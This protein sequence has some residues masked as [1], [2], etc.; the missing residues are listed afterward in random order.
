MHGALDD[1]I[2]AI[3]T[4]PGEGGI[5]VV[6]VSGLHAL[7]V[8][9]QVVFP[10]SGKLLS[11]LLSHKMTV[12]D[13]CPPARTSGGAHGGATVARTALDE[14]LVVV[15]KAPR[16]Y[17]G[18][19]V[20][21]VQCHG[22]PVALD[23]LCRGLLVAGARLAEPGEFT[24][25]A[26]LNGKLDLSQAEAVLDTIRAKTAR[27][28][29]VAQS[30]RRGELSRDVEE[31]RSDLVTALAHIEAALDF[32]DEDIAFVEKAELLRILE[33][34]RHRLQRLVDSGRQGR[35]LRE[36]A[37]VAILG[38]PNV[39]KSSLLNAL[40]QSDR[41]IVTPIPGTTRDILEELLSIAGIPVRLVDTA[42]IRHTDDLVEAEGIRRSKLAWEDADLA[43]I[44]LDGSEPLSAEDLAL[45]T[46]PEAVAAILVVNKCDLPAQLTRAQL[47]AVCPDHGGIV[48]I[49]ATMRIG[50]DALR[51][52][53]RD[54]LMTNQ[55]ESRDGVLVTNLRHADACS[56]ALLGV[57]Q[58]LQ[59]AAA[60]HA[61]EL[62]AVDLRLA[63]DA[64]GEI[65][66]VITTDEILE[67]IF[68]EFCIGK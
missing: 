33:A 4:P 3:A 26:F 11:E 1:T 23:Q 2:C 22:G 28:L 62:I 44:L 63:A 48:D 12:A 37:V 39:G 32:G 38:R 45:V 55:L 20:V 50:L 31:I 15:M 17:T 65:T 10:R 14:A 35:I 41:A 34:A 68:S 16:S 6:R 36:G 59:S 54:R 67:R 60:D 18:E 21:E 29:S 40:L 57:E 64:L 9:A 58:A 13:V 49:S 46:S 8:A 42:G 56:R 52:M 24:K 43:L 61:G 30:Q 51:G 66:G 7:D 53:I 25:R 19:D 27:S 5:G 47:D